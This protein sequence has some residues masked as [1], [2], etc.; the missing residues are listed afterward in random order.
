MRLVYT[1]TI[2][3]KEE[4]IPHDPQQMVFIFKDGSRYNYLLNDQAWINDADAGI[5]TPSAKWVANGIP[6]ALTMNLSVMARYLSIKG[7]WKN[8][9]GWGHTNAMQKSSGTEFMVLTNRPMD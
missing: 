5:F 6:H 7:R 8:T 2:N 4:F 3:G 9:S 1:V